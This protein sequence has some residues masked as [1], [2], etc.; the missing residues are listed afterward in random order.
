MLKNILLCI[1]FTLS[2]AFGGYF[3]KKASSDKGSIL[4]IIFNKNLYIGGILYVAGAL[5][6]IIVLKRLNYI[7][8]L[9]LTSITYVWTMII[10]YFIL[11]EKITIKK[12]IGVMFIVFG[13]LILVL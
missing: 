9:P 7:V 8:V 4:K 11:G 10:S 2:G 12:I 3:F 5:L 1:I 13:A 6:N